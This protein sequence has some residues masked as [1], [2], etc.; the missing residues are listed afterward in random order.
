MALRS[1]YDEYLQAYTPDRFMEFYTSMGEE[2]F[3]R[4]NPSRPIP[5]SH[6]P[7]VLDPA[8]EAQFDRAIS[9]LWRTLGNRTYQE[10]SAESIPKP[11]RPPP[12][13][14][15]PGIPF[16]PAHNIG[17]IDLHPDRGALKMI[18]FMV[19]PPGCVG[20]YP[21]M[22]EHYHAY[23]KGLLPDRHAFCFREG[24]NRERCEEAMVSQIVGAAEIERVAIVDW[25]PGR[26]VTYGEFCY[27][28]DMLKRRRGVKGVIADPREID[29]R[30]GRVFAKGLPVERI[31][32]RVTLLDWTD[33]HRAFEP[34]TR[35]LWESP[36]IFVHHPYLWY[37]GDKVSLTLLSDPS[38]LRRMGLPP[39]DA[40]KMLELV[41]RTLPL[42][43]FC[44]R[45]SS[46]VDVSRLMECFG[47]PANLVLKPVSSHGSKGII[48]GPVDTPTVEALEGTLRNIDPSQYAAMEYVSIPEIPV[49]RGG[50]EQ[51][52]WHYDMRIFVLNGQYVFP[53]GRVYYGDYTNQ[54]PCRGFAPLFFA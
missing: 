41:P 24:W 3:L 19:L 39:S 12:S 36:E 22:L 16:D 2:L 49:P 44:H 26:Q 7:I 17:C 21:G 54:V 31:L 18:E 1:Y 13:S 37:I 32:N 8:F 43:S 27:T 23:L 34:Y 40:E 46:D 35:L 38:A 25:E 4:A 45:G 51:E 33:H 10:L 47:G 42:R 28:L 50:G 9:L 48:L 11:I 20:V 52:M 30:G 6:V 5:F 15:A 53:G 14:K 29:T